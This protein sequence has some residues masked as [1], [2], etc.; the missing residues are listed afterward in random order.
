MGGMEREF[1]VCGWLGEGGCGKR[2]PVRAGITVKAMDLVACIQA[3]LENLT[4]CRICG[5]ADQQT[6]RRINTLIDLFIG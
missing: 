2:G 6:D 4:G 5:R 1:D 3:T